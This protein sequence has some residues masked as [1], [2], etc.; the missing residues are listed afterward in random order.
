MDLLS[1]LGVLARRWF[2]VLPLLLLAGGLAAA[3]WVTS[4]PTY[5]T[6]ATVLLRFPVGVDQELVGRN[7]YL[8]YGNLFVPGKVVTD[9]VNSP[10]YAARLRASGVEG[11]YLTGVDTTTQAPI[12]AIR[13]EDTSEA[14]TTAT[15]LAVIESLKQVLRARQEAAGA[16][17]ESWATLEVVEPPGAPTA[18]NTSRLR[19]A[20]GA[21]AV[22]GMLAVGAAL[23]LEARSRRGRRGA[24]AVAPGGRDAPC[25][26]C[27]EWLAQ[28]RLVQ[29]LELQHGLGPGIP[30]S[31]PVGRDRARLGPHGRRGGQAPAG[32]RPGRAACTA[33]RGVAARQDSALTSL[34]TRGRSLVT[35]RDLSGL[36]R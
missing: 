36:S 20:G 16:P 18:L 33:A 29:H 32:D 22:G 25:G 3:T 7:P 19:A 30:G 5:Q 15:T 27:G 21:L 23:L 26:L 34:D 10:A 17:E 14:G 8:G 31:R 12:I 4:T 11:T 28:E 24:L 1:F 2:V 35:Q 9:V 13:S 6:T